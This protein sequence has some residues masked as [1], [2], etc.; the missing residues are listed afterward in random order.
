MFVNKTFHIQIHTSVW[1]ISI[2]VGS[3]KQEC[4]ALSTTKTEYIALYTIA[5]EAAWLWG[6]LGFLEF[7]QHTPTT[8]YQDNQSTIALVGNGKT[9]QRTKHIKVHFHYTCNKILDETKKIEYFSSDKMI[10]DRLT[11][12]LT[13]E[14][15]VRL[16]DGIMMPRNVDGTSGGSVWT[17]HQRR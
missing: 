2:G 11:K 3:K 6:L 14:Q 9:S 17:P 13:L 12:S 1:Q 5:K 16:R 10:A 8:V 4:V 15:F 7:V